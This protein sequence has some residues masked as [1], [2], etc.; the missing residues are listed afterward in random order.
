[1]PTHPLNQGKLL[2]E[3]ELSEQIDRIVVTNKSKNFN[4]ELVKLFQEQKEL[5][6]KEAYEDWHGNTGL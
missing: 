3:Q 2:T 1:M 6:V 4:V 5:A